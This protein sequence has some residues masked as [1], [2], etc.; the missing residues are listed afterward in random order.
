MMTYALDTN[1]IIDYLRN[2]LSVTKNMINAYIDG[3]V[4][5]LPTVSY[6]EVYRGFK[7]ANETKKF[8]RFQELCKILKFLY[9]DRDNVKIFHISA[10]IYT[11]LCQKGQK[12]EDNDIYIA[13]TAIANDAVLVTDNIKH[14]SRIDGLKLVSWKE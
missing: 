13:A 7:G 10:Q 12:I 4:L 14:F 1:V 3:H 6:Y 11:A 8:K 5:A 2:N 9:M